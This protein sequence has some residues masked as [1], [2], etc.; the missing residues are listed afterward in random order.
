[1]KPSRTRLTCRAHNRFSP[2]IVLWQHFVGLDRP[3]LA[4]QRPSSTAAKVAQSTR[5]NDYGLL[6]SRD[7]SG[8]TQTKAH[9]A[10]EEHEPH[11][12]SKVTVRKTLATKGTWHATKVE[13]STIKNVQKQYD[14]RKASVTASE[15]LLATARA[16]FEAAEDYT[17]VVVQPIMH[18]T[19]IKDSSLPWCLPKE[20]R[21]MPGIDR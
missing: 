20:E 9:S 7:A 3:C 21:T 8:L 18:P 15:Q 10:Q 17:G 16:A 5:N 13:A 6:N 4:Q 1:M 12:K 2:S 11:E 14:A 19:P